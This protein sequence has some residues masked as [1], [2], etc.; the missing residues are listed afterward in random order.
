MEVRSFVPKI[1]LSPARETGILAAAEHRQKRLNFAIVTPSYNKVRYIQRCVESI[2]DQPDPGLDY[3]LLDN[4]SNDGSAEIIQRLKARYGSRM[5]LVVEKD[6]G[7]SEAINRGFTLAKGEIMGWL[8]ADDFFLPDTFEKVRRFFE[9]NPDVDMVYGKVRI[10]DGDFKYLGDF[11][12]Q[13][14]NLQ[15]LY[16]Y[17]YIAQPGCFW[18]RRLWDKVGPLDRSLNWGLDWDLF[19][20]MTKQGKTAL[21]DEYLADVVVDGQHKTA[22]GGIKRTRELGMI[23]RRHGGWLAPTHL[24]CQYIRLIYWLARPWQNWK[25]TSVLANKAVIRAQVLATGML[26]K[27]FRAQVMC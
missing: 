10:Y 19:I 23:S 11:P 6:G 1:G 9:A 8:N 26:Y 12:V 22:T 5:N 14:P 20:R 3:W 2:L 13:P 21:L 27:T 4:C 24:F 15:T 25:P 17:D 16:S 18:R 7:Q